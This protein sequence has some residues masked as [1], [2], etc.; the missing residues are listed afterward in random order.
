[1]EDREEQRRRR[2]LGLEVLPLRLPGFPV[3]VEIVVVV[4]VVVVEIVEVGEIT[5]DQ[6]QPHGNQPPIEK[7][8]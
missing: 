6:P 3:V 8:D 7:L 1:L 5:L 4:V 2:L